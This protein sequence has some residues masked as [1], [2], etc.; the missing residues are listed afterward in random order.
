[1]KHAFR[2]ILLSFLVTLSAYTEEE[3]FW[4]PIQ[5]PNLYPFFSGLI[6]PLPERGRLV[7]YGEGTIRFSINYGN[8]FRYDA[9]YWH[10]GYYL[11]VDNETG[12]LDIDLRYGVHPCA[13]AQLTLRTGFLHGG[14]SDAVIQ[15]YHEMFGFPNDHRAGV[16][17]ND[18]NL[19]ITGPDGLAFRYQHAAKGL[20]SLDTNVK[21]DAGHSLK[22][23]T[24][25]SLL[26]GIKWPLSSE[27]PLSSGARDYKLGF[28]IEQQ[29]VKHA[30]YMNWGLLYIN[31]PEAL[32]GFTWDTASVSYA[33]AW[34][35][36]IFG[37]SSF[38]A[39]VHGVTSPYSTGHRRID[40]DSTYLTLG[41][42]KSFRHGTVFT[43]SVAE[44]FLKYPFTDEMFTYANTD[45]SA[46][47]DVTVPF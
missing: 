21:I 1:M 25:V 10:E 36:S 2:L 26:A 29:F 3:H 20:M 11:I 22:H 12:I 13:E 33:V 9:G 45:I 30:L 32:E 14:Y 17:N 24:Q 46:Q 15:A 42:R 18:I 16:E 39:Q 19:I 7:E 47:F 6:Q 28:A 27:F 5:A 43:C 23:N 4:G 44:E 35:W 38:V 41:F 31:K 40:N 34:E 8:N 37:N